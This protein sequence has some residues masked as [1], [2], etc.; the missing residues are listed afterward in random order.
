M[1]G[2][3]GVTLVGLASPPHS[4]PETLFFGGSLEILYKVL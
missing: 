2:Q 4:K 1:Q 3:K